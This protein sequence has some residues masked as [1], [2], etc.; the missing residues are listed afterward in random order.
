M[1]KGIIYVMETVVPG[2]VKIG[3]T[4]TGNFEGRMYSLERNGYFN[5]VGLKRRFAIEVEDYDEKEALLDEIFSKARVPGSELFALDID[6]VIQLLA[7]FD[8]KQVYPETETREESFDQATEKRHMKDDWTSIP[9]GTYHLKQTR[10]GKGTAV[11][12]MV[13]EDGAFIVKAGAKC[14]PVNEGV[15]W[16][17][18]PRRTAPI[19][20]GVLQADVVTKSPSTAGWVVLGG[21]TNG[22]NVWKDESGKMLDEYRKK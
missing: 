19:V 8:G 18:E 17:P 16:T 20:D 12:Q 4:G 3:K 22:W 9:D 7:S 21:S 15:V 2:L 13:V 11:A 5:V 10:K 1:A 6:L 14:L